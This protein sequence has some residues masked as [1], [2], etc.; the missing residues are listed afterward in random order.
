MS[1]SITE[2]VIRAA[3]AAEGSLAGQLRADT[4]FFEAGLNSNRLASAV[5]VLAAAGLDV[6]LVDMFRHPT[7]RELAG[8]LDR[9][10]TGSGRDR[11][12]D[13]GEGLPWERRRR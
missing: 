2:D 4:N 7:V 9:R 6:S 8:V 10:R 3:L 1:P 5:D 11:S 12:R 13:P